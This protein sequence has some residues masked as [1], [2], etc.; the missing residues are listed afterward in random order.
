LTILTR[1]EDGLIKQVEIFHRPL[2]VVA[3]FSKELGKRVAGK[4]DASLF[5]PP[6]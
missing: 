2:Q 6:G 1:D 3:R 5:E 4:L